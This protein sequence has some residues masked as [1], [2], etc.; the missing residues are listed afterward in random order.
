MSDGNVCGGTNTFLIG[1]I[2]TLLDVIGTA[3]CGT[4]SDSVS[5][6]CFRRRHHSDTY[7]DGGVQKKKHLYYFVRRNHELTPPPP[8][9]LILIQNLHLDRATLHVRTRMERLDRVLNREPM[10]HQLPDPRQHPTI[11]Q[12][13]R[14]RPRITIAILEPQVDLSG[15]QPHERERHLVL[16]HAHHKH[17]SSEPHRMDRRRNRAL[18]TRALQRN[19]RLAPKRRFDL[20]RELLRALVA[21]HEIRSQRAGFVRDESLR[22]VEAALIDV[23]DNDGLGAGCARA[24][25]RDEADWAGAADEDRVAELQLGAVDGGE[26]D[27]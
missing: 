12:P 5:R 20:R 27:G 26:C 8:P 15:T 18:N 16:A 19:V 17:R 23:C 3:F 14:P 9:P 13:D 11:Q 6:V 21:R 2:C 10:C 4:A 22:K 7:I 1:P 25:Q 24:Q